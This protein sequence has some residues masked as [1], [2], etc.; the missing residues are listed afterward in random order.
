MYS[1]EY[2][3]VYRSGQQIEDYDRYRYVNQ[4]MVNGFKNEIESM[5]KMQQLVIRCLK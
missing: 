1:I 5:Y 2:A 3:I 4:R